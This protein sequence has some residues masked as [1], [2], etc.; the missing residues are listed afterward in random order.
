MRRITLFLLAALLLLVAFAL[1]PLGC[2][3]IPP[4]ST[5]GGTGGTT[6]SATSSSG[7]TTT[8]TTTSGG[9]ATTTSTGPGGSGGGGGAGGAAPGVQ[10]PVTFSYNPGF[11]VEGVQ[12]AGEWQNFDLS[13]APMLMNN[14]GTY[15][16]TVMLAPGTWAYK[17]VF[18]DSG[19]M[20]NWVLDP[21]QGRRKFVGGIENSAIKVRD[22]SKPWFTVTSSQPSRPASG[23]GTYQAQL[24]YVDAID[25]S[26]PEPSGFT[27]SLVKDGAS[28]PLSAT[29][30]KVDASGNVT[31]SLSGL[32]DGK[33]RVVLTDKSKS[34][35]VSDPIYLIFWIEAQ[36]FSWQ[37]A[38]IYMVV[39]DRYKDGDPSND[40]PSPT[41]NVDPREDWQGGDYQGVTASINDGTLDKLGVRAIWLTPFNTNPPDAWPASD[42][43]H[44]VTG[45][46]GYWPIKAREVEPRVGGAAALKALVVA[47]HQHGI[48]VMQD[49][50]IHHVHQEHEYVAAHPDWFS[51]GCV[52]GTSNCDWT[53]HALDCVFSTYL[54]NVN[55]QNPAAN[56]QMMAD[57]VWWVDDF[58]LDGLR[59]DAV[60]QVPQA[61]P[62]NLAASI[63]ET[64]EPGGTHY[65]LLGE[66]AMGW[67]NCADP[68]NDINYD[69]ISQYIGPLDLD[70]QFDFVLYYAVSTTMMAYGD[71]GMIHADY[72]YTH[73]LTKW[74][75]GSIM[76]P[77]LGSH[78]TPRFVTIADYRGQDAA[79]DRSIP[80][81]EFTNVAVAPSDGE[82]YRRARIAFAWLLG[83]QGAPLIYYGDEYGQWGG[84]DPNNR[85]MWRPET[86]LNANE[87][88]TL[89]FIRKASLARQSVPAMRR[90]AYVSIYNT[91]ENT[92][93]FGR[94][95]SP[96][97]AAVVGVTRSTTPVTVSNVDLATP[98]GFAAGTVLHDAMGGPDVTVGSG[99]TTSITVPASGSVVL[100]P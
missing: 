48:R 51:Q 73:G 52:C 95:V 70:G 14:S 16:G 96:G 58:D 65:F 53:V 26:G 23:Q 67:N 87:S 94:L 88:A 38:T 15:S 44:M 83:L 19:G 18:T 54:P 55:Y 20:P 71:Q 41:P 90:G 47:A 63:R 40:I 2:A 75:Q 11:S 27:G 78:D 24:A 34:G 8:T 64:F 35:K 42:N 99:A 82:P 69:T 45:Y 31:V 59:V 85:Q 4:Y 22:C 68:C 21:N 6:G 92:L 57:A 66:T 76:T 10:C 3:D 56:D 81:N 84:A 9:G 79:H 36:T 7:T 77:Y 1:S 62:R 49:F 25:A 43:V 30:L 12:V 89:A 17:I 100:H 13:S 80:G 37:D 33:Y 50:V 72:W 61:A 97:Q 74:P 5:A 91:D 86:A 32:A 93:V 39:T 98:L 60:K 29:Q 28:T 46:H